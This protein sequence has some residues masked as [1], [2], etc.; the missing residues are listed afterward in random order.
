MSTEV[1]DQ[2]ISPLC[3]AGGLA[4][5][6]AYTRAATVYRLALVDRSAP[7]APLNT[8]HFT[9]TGHSVRKGANGRVLKQPRMYV[10]PGAAP[11]TVAFLDFHPVTEDEVF[12]D[13]IT[14]RPDMRG[15]SYG[16]YLASAFYERCASCGI[17]SV[18][19]GKIMH[20]SAVA[21]WNRMK[22]DYPNVHSYGKWV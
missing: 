15:Q 22:V 5:E 12:I 9:D 4:P 3:I 21:I 19:W 2:G 7:D 18:D 14:V 10:I 1:V 20:D 11:K 8:L 6:Y 17:T 13:F 16:W